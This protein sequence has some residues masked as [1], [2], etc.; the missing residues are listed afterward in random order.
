VFFFRYIYI[1][2]HLWC[3]YYHNKNCGE[4]VFFGEGIFMKNGFFGLFGLV[5]LLVVV[6]VGAYQYP[7]PEAVQQAN[8]QYGI[9]GAEGTLEQWFDVCYNTCDA[10]GGNVSDCKTNPSYGCDNM[11]NCDLSGDTCSFTCNA[12][13]D[14]VYNNVSCPCVEDWTRIDVGVCDGLLSNFTVEYVDNGSCGT[15]ANLPVDNGTLVFCCVEDWSGGFGLCRNG[16]HTLS[17]VDLGVCNTSYQ[18]PVDNGSVSG[19]VEQVQGGGGATQF[20]VPV[21]EVKE[22]VVVSQSVVGDGVSADASGL[23]KLWNNILNWLMFWK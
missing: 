1:V 22:V 3:L 12:Y 20:V 23:A 15:T 2:N 13:A 10:I 21:V 16:V 5:L 18:L 7:V 19:C 17:Y 11:Y 9:C 14:C 4:C 8:T 6:G